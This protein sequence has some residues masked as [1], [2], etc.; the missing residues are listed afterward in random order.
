MTKVPSDPKTKL[1]RKEVSNALAELG[2]PIS[3]ATLATMATRGGGPPYRRWG[4]RV[5]Y[6]WAEVLNWVEE[7]RGPE[8]G[9]PTARIAVTN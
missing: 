8:R 1:G 6:V 4:S 3:P 7:R 2:F 5:Q 9:K